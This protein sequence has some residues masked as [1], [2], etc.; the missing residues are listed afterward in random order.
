MYY[1]KRAVDIEVVKIVPIKSSTHGNNI[2]LVSCCVQCSI[3]MKK[4]EAQINH[5]LFQYE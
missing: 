1:F 3:F 2:L 5:T 4:F